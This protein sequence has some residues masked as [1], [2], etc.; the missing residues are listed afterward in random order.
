MAIELGDF[1]ISDA[2]IMVKY[3]TRSGA[4]GKNGLVPRHDANTGFVAPHSTDLGLV[5]DIPKFD[6]TIPNTDSNE[7]TIIRP[8]DRTDISIGSCLHKCQRRSSGSV[9]NIDLSIQTDD[10][11]ISG[12]PIKQVEVIIIY[13]TWCIEYTLRGGEDLACGLGRPK[14]T[15]VLGSKVNW[16]E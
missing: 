1:V 9:P 5:L 3:L 11:H 12:R 15:V 13:K 6:I 4:G 10:N 2:D 14:R 7:P 16:L 8:L